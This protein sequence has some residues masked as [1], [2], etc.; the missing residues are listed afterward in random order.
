[1]NLLHLKYA[2]EV[3][4]T[5]SINKAAEALLIAQPNLSRSIKELEANLGITIFE[6]SSKGMFPT[7]QG[8]EF[9]GYANS[10][11]SQID[12]V[13]KMYKNGIPAKRRFSVS[14][15]RATYISEAFAQFSKGLSSDS[16][17]IFYKETNSS[18]T[19]K[20]IL[21]NDYRLG[22]VRY[23]D[24]YDKYFKSMFDEKGLVY[25]VISEFHYL[26]AMNRECPL[27][28]LP[29]IHFSDL[30]SLT[31]IAHADPFVPSLSMAQVKKEELPDNISRRIFVFERASQFDL[32]SENNQLFMWVSPIP[33]KTLD[34]YGLVQRVCP[35]NTKNYKD[36]L[37]Y[38]K[39]YKLTEMDKNF[40][41]ELC[42]SK[43]RYL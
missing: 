30:E 29:E 6:R 14:V 43:R 22:I 38:K 20:N 34:R 23:A 5:G 27:A 33:Q 25:E 31:E 13:E 37:I 9:I 24:N 3:A 40:I 36:V 32:L 17:E 26:L 11:L 12:D 2:V 10:I 39:D 35:E 21:Y 4:R 1:M 42:R 18:R 7:P 19:V 41:T 16:A 15:P 28:A 8:E